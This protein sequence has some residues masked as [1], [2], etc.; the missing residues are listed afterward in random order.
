MALLAVAGCENDAHVVDAPVSSV[1]WEHLHQ[2]D[3]EEPICFDATVTRP[4]DT[5]IRCEWICLA[6][7]T[8]THGAGRYYVSREWIRVDAEPQPQWVSAQWFPYPDNQ[9]ETSWPCDGEDA[10]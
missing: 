5:H 4:N 1:H 8:N 2:F 6:F 10:P 3:G 7:W 9:H